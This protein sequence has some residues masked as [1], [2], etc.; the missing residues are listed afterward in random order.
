MRHVDW[1]RLIR[2]GLLLGFGVLIVRLLATGQMRFYMSPGL[3]PLMVLT[4]LLLLG[5]G[6]PE[7]KGAWPARAAA[8]RMRSELDLALTFGL[9]ALPLLLGSLVTPR[10]LSSTALGGMPV[11]KI[12][13]AFSPGPLPSGIPPVPQRPI[14]DFPELLSYLAQAGENGVNQHVR[15][16]GLVSRSDDLAPNE[17]VLLRYTIVHC[18]A[19]AQPLGILIRAE[20]GAA[21]TTDQWVEVE[22]RLASEPR[23]AERLVSIKAEQ[24]VASDEPTDPYVAAF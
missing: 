10:A 17:F 9:V 13:L 16:R 7:L 8:N 6:F 15:A 3:N 21:W 12:V 23:G 2:A 5:M 22:G 24:I 1:F 19:D 14:A 20:S 4:A 18:V 11:S